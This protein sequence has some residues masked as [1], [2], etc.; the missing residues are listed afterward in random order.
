MGA[1]LPLE[2]AKSLSSQ[3]RPGARWN[4]DRADETDFRG[5]RTRQ[6]SAPRV[7]YSF[8]VDLT[9]RTDFVIRSKAIKGNGR[10]AKPIATEKGASAPPRKGPAELPEKVKKLTLRAFQKTYEAHHKG[11]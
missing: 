5:I 1:D 10:Q 3:V 6:T 7:L 9:D 2:Q 4:E 11:S 8:G